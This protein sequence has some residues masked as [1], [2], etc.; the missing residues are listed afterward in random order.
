MIT[1]AQR[2]NMNRLRIHPAAASEVVRPRSVLVPVAGAIQREKPSA[3]AATGG[4]AAA[5]RT[6]PAAMSMP[7]GSVV[8]DKH[9]FLLQ[10][11]GSYF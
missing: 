5:P 9:L 2:E 1:G 8:K 3:T 6:S 7:R 10:S 4:A 11:D